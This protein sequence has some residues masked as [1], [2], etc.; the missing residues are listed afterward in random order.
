M[1]VLPTGDDD[2]APVHCGT[3]LGRA[4]HPPWSVTL[5]L[6]HVFH[7]LDLEGQML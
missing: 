3:F 2:F 5:F 7:A 1:D 6:G 4:L